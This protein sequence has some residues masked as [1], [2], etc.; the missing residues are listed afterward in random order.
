MKRKETTANIQPGLWPQDD[1]NPFLKP[2]NKEA[3]RL[4]EQKAPL[5]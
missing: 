4:Q 2:L 3:E 5:K 1:N